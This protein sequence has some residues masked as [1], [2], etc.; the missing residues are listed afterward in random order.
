M[1]LLWGVIRLFVMGYGFIVRAEKN[2]FFIW[3]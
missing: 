2:L 3:D 1:N